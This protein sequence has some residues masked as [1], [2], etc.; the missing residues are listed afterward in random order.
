VALAVVF[1]FRVFSFH[2]PVVL[3]PGRARLLQARQLVA[4]APDRGYPAFVLFGRALPPQ[5]PRHLAE[6]PVDE[7]QTADLR[8]VARVHLHRQAGA[9]RI[10]DAEV[11][12]RDPAAESALP[13]PA[14]RLAPRLI[15]VRAIDH[16]LT[17]QVHLGN[18]MRV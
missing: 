5:V 7:I 9:C 15:F 11:P 2:L 18:V 10:A 17:A 3:V 8:H 6:S 12:C 1:L 14:Q 16:V 4:V 13:H